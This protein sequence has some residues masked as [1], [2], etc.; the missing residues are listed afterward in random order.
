MNT[1]TLPPQPDP[2]LPSEDKQRAARKSTLVSVAVNI[3]LTLTQI[4]VGIVSKSS[5][6]VA[7]GVHSLSDLIADFVVLFANQHSH[8]AADD[9]HHYGHARF[10]TAAS[11]ILGVLLLAVGLGMLWSAAMKFRTPEAIPKVHLVALWV[12][13]GALVVKEGLFRYMLAVAERVKSG[14]LVA[15]AWHA[16]SDAASSLVVAVGIVGNLLGA[17]LLDPL[18]AAIVGFMVSKMGWEFGMT[19]FNDLMDQA[20]DR[21]QVEAIRTTLAETP[22]VMDVHDLRTR[23]MGDLAVVDVHL[24]VR[25]HVSVSEGHQVGLQARQRVIERFPV[26]D[27][28]VHIDADPTKDP[29]N[30]ASPTRES[31]LASLNTALG[32]P[33]LKLDD[34]VLHYLAGRVELDIFLVLD[35]EL[36]ERVRAAAAT[37][38]EI[39]FT[40]FFARLD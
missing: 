19:A 31:I 20:V 16:R 28:T 3:V 40:R 8:K 18:A 34:L 21:E 27:V 9:N 4:L 13:L 30:L 39:V 33:L 12:A 1:K 29:G 23:K 35:P 2:D 26:L 22:G 25:S 36:R 37:V 32:A 17:P 7:D 6:L 24:M 38:P 14:M 15:N 5:G 10:E 11:L